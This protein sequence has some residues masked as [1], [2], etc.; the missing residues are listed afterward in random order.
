VN[1]E[2]ALEEE[3]F[4]PNPEQPVQH[5]PRT[6]PYTS[7]LDDPLPPG[8]YVGVDLDNLIEKVFVAPDAPN[9]IKEMVELIVQR[10]GCDS[11]IVEKSSLK[12]PL[13]K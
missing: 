6:E 11:G 7:I 4:L 1:T 13:L 5:Y 12:S 9:W 10:Y 8:K 3:L 2:R